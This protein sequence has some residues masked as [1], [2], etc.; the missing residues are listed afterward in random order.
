LTVTRA[1]GELRSALGVYV[2]G[3]I[4]PADRDAVDSHLA[5]CADCRDQL[6]DLA[7]LPALLRRIPPDEVESL[8]S[9]GD[10]DRGNTMPEGL[11][12]SLLTRAAKR[13]RNRRLAKVAAAVLV[14]AGIGTMYVALGTTPRH[15]VP[16]ALP[17]AVTVSGSSPG[18]HVSATIRYAGRP[19]GVQLSVQVTGVAAGTTCVLEVTGS[20]GL[21]S[22]AGSWTV[23]AGDGDSW[24]A[25][26]ASVPVTDVR[27]FVVMDGAKA[28]VRVDVPRSVATQGS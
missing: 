24:Y 8:L 6:A 27:G 16:T 9:D 28:L 22:E 5:S 11:L 17:G 15:P 3:A 7:G 10:A 12:A 2:L 26:S 13:K 18:D 19:W 14:A 20:G 23:A 1:C 4:V 25:A 21:E